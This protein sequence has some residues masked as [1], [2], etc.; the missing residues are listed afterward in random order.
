[1]AFV[2]VMISCSK[3]DGN[4]DPGEVT[5]GEIFT[6]QAVKIQIPEG[7]TLDQPMY[8]GTINGIPVKL[9]RGSNNTLVFYLPSD[10]EAGAAELVIPAL[11]N[12]TVDY[13]IQQTVLT[14][15]ADEVM[16]GY[17]SSLDIYAQNLGDSPQ[18]QALAHNIENLG[19][20]YEAADVQ[21]KNE[22]ALA[23]QANK[24]AFDGVLAISMER[25]SDDDTARAVFKIGLATAAIV[26]GVALVAALTVTGITTA[27]LA[28]AALGAVTVCAGLVLINNTIDDIFEVNVIK[29]KLNLGGFF[30]I[31]D[32]T[33]TPRFLHNTS[34][35]ITFQADQ[36]GLNQSDQGRSDEHTAE[37]FD[38]FGDFNS[39]VGITNNG[40]GIINTQV[41][42][43][44]LHSMSATPLPS[45]NSFTTANVD[46]ETFGN[47][48]L[49]VTHPNLVLEEYSLL[50]DGQLKVKIKVTG[51]PPSREIESFLNYTFDNGFSSFTGKFPIIIEIPLQGSW[52]AIQIENFPVGEWINY[53]YEECPNIVYHQTKYLNQTLQFEESIFSVTTNSSEREPQIVYNSSNCT[54]QSTGPTNEYEIVNNVETATFSLN[55]NT[56]TID[57]GDGDIISTDIEFI[58][59]DK[60]KFEDDIFVRQ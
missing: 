44:D 59:A 10:M 39:Y 55:G 20:I 41:D 33:Q 24:A 18:A 36:R 58:S 22:M 16:E 31:N 53:T 60:I 48:T 2:A 52:N 29:D 3:D 13:N 25:N 14:G 6:S 26:E 57:W 12:I 46:S 8:D 1:M 40:I 5:G 11:S 47:I 45:G 50:A 21:G 19:D 51:T 34:R 17:F 49:S 4:E 56:I 37:F 43:A 27:A 32:R 28:P 9:V 42:G 35:I 54:S 7:T 15:T 38:Y 23:Y 30:G